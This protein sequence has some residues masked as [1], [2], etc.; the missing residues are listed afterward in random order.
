MPV[1]EERWRAV[2]ASWSPSGVLAYTALAV[3]PAVVI[4]IGGMPLAI[5]WGVL[6]GLL[7]LHAPS[8][9]AKVRR[10][11]ALILGVGV[12]LLLNLPADPPARTWCIPLDGG[13]PYV[14][15][16]RAACPR[17]PLQPPGRVEPQPPGR[18]EPESTFFGA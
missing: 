2:S 1:V 4:A 7:I 11:G 9:G 6:A 18:V 14:L 15:R 10:A 8:D 17:Q 5:A 3:V 12:G 16:H 13:R